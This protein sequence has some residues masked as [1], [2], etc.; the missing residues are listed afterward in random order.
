M[1]RIVSLLLVSILLCAAIFPASAA[2]VEPV[3]PLFTYIKSATTTLTIDESTGIAYCYAKCYTARD[4]V[5]IKIVGLLQQY[6]AGS[7]VHV[8]SWTAT[9]TKLVIMDEQWAVYSGYQYRFKALVYIHDA[10]GNYL[11][12]T[13]FVG[14]YDYT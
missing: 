11:E 3:E 5:T 9:G 4:D 12:S 13:S 14:T 8:K 6:K 1:K 7:W 2:V 10:E